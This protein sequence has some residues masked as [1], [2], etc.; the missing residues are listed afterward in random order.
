MLKFLMRFTFHSQSR[1]TKI[2]ILKEMEILILINSIIPPEPKK[3]SSG[4]EIYDKV[5]NVY[6]LRDS[7]H[8]KC[9]CL[10]YSRIL[11][12]FSKCYV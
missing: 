3:I 9:S 1:F 2:M 4:D 5:W 12:L 11:G 7:L 6:L 10:I 8:C